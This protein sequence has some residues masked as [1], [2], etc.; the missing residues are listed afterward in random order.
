M[1]QYFNGKDVAAEILFDMHAD[2][3]Q[4]VNVVGMDAYGPELEE[5][6]A[7]LKAHLQF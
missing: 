6:R 5:L 3:L 2:P 4:E 1:I 7:M